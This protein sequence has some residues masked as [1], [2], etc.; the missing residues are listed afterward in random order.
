VV[1]ISGF[2]WIE[3]HKTTILKHNLSFT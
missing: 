3:P 1:K 2:V